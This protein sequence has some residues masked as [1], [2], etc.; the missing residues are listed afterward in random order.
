[1]LRPIDIMTQVHIE[2]T[3]FGAQHILDLAID[4]SWAW[5]TMATK[6]AIWDFFQLWAHLA[7]TPFPKT[8]R[9]EQRPTDMLDTYNLIPNLR[10]SSV[11]VGPVLHLPQ[12]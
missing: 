2:D 6:C 12:S 9:F 10:H 7:T 3:Y 5:S 11:Q 1:M 8:E 4:S